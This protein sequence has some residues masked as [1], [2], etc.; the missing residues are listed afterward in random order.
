MNREYP[1]WHS[2]YNRVSIYYLYV[3]LLND[4]LVI[5]TLRVESYSYWVYSPRDISERIHF[6]R[7]WAQGSGF[8]NNSEFSFTWQLIWNM[9]LLSDWA[10]K[11]GLADLP[12]CLHCSSGLEETAEHAFYYCEAVLLILESCQGVYSW[13]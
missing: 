5:L 8:L 11:A 1:L 13:H 2:K 10:F 6:Q 7:N 3:V 12:D 4:K 9:L